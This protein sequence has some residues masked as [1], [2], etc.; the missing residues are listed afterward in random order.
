MNELEVSEHKM[1]MKVEPIWRPLNLSDI[2]SRVSSAAC[3]CA[4]AD[5]HELFCARFLSSQY[6]D[7]KDNF[8][9]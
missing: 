1:M 2:T 5:T 3:T 7:Y 8:L 9:Q 4:I 6:S